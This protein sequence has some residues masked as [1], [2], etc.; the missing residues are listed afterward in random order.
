MVD[1]GKRDPTSSRKITSNVG[2]GFDNLITQAPIC[3]SRYPC[4]TNSPTEANWRS[5]FL[6]LGL[7]T[8]VFV[9][10]VMFSSE[11]SLEFRAGHTAG[12][13]AST[14]ALC[15][16]PFLTWRYATRVGRRQTLGAAFNAFVILTVICWFVL[17]VIVRGV[18]PNLI[19]QMQTTSTV[20][21]QQAPPSVIG[22]SAN[23][24][25]AKNPTY[26]TLGWTQESSESTEVGPWLNYDPPGTRY[27]RY[28]DRL[29]HKLYPPGVRPNA[30]PANR[31]CLGDSSAALYQ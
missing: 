29:I 13:L 14:A 12:A 20:Q 18:L 9:L 30:E 11:G 21:T 6:G 27:C 25:S 2:L 23:H 4:M 22:G 10:K 24:D 17:F 16:L 8:S 19:L 28:G 1:S 15:L 5:P 26:E 31:F 3:Q 7:I